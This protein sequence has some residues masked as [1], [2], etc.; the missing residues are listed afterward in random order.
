V[1][2]DVEESGWK[3]RLGAAR[4][5]EVFGT[6]CSSGK[7]KELHRGLGVHCAAGGSAVPFP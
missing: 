1:G 6:G 5:R 3:K 7:G 2:G 4:S